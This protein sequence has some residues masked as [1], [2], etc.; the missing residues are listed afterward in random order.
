MNESLLQLMLEDQLMCF[1]RVNGI[2][3]SGDPATAAH[4]CAEQCTVLEA[5]KW[6]TYDSEAHSCVLTEDREFMSDCVSCT[7][8]HDDCMQKGTSGMILCGY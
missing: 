2:F 7:Y 6:F 8:G 4:E 3:I 5:C 1:N